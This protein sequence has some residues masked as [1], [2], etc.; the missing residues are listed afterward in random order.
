MRPSS[1]ERS[2][3]VWT[4]ELWRT[5]FETGNPYRRYKW[6]RDRQLAADLIQPQPNQRILEV[7]CGY[8]RISEVLLSCPGI[9]W[10][11]VDQSPDML[12]ACL[13]NLEGSFFP[14]RADAGRLPFQDGAFDAVLCNG[15][16]MHLRD[17][18]SALAEL[19]RVLRPGGRL[20]VSANNLLSP[21]AFPVWLWVQARRGPYQAFRTPHFYRRRLRQLGIVLQRIVGDTLLA[22]A[23]QMPGSGRSAPPTVLFPLLRTLDRWVDRPPLNHLAYEVWFQG[24]KERSEKG[25]RA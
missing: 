20:V 12:R 23:I 15:V 9:R 18:G 22:V 24:T 3:A 21:F 6:S 7:G 13:Q 17:P 2:G 10:V 16:L 11:G 8:G 5:Y 25:A 19:C 1:A 14:C 4:P